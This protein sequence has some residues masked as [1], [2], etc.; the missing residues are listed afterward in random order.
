MLNITHYHRPTT[1]KEA[2]ALLVPGRAVIAGGTDLMVNPRYT[3]GVTELVDIT[4]L[5]LAYI[6]LA[7]CRK[8]TGWVYLGAATTMY[9][10]QN[11]TLLASIAGGVLAK[12]AATCGSPNIRNVATIG[13][14]ICSALPSGD[15]LTTLLALDARVAL[16][17]PLGHRELPLSDFFLGPARTVLQQE[18]L[19]EI[20]FQVPHPPSGA[21][22]Y[23]LGR[24][25]EDISIVNTA[26]LL[27][28][29]SQGRVAKARIAAGAV[30]PTPLRALQAEE[31][32]TGKFPGPD[33]LNEA[34]RLTMAAVSPITDQR[35]TADYRRKVTRVCA[36]RALEQALASCGPLNQAAI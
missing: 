4:G 22:F 16:Q 26:A 24:T 14:N 25:E 3:Q 10:V 7:D 34:A 19:V 8:A 9:E 27:C 12:A 29:D 36:L 20:S 35:A 32:L 30:A 15:T 18:L 11:S 2:V 23:K 1:L 21:A 33:N 31:F 13:G 17:G 28:L 5:G 6:R